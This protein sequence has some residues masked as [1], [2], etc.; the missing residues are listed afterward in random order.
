MSPMV[1]EAV[2][3]S[4][5]DVKGGTW[6]PAVVVDGVVYVG[7][8]HGVFAFESAISRLM[9]IGDNPTRLTHQQI[10]LLELCPE[11]RDSPSECA[12]AMDLTSQGLIDLHGTLNHLTAP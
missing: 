8:G 10:L 4:C 2:P 1:R 9:V 5:M 7:N 6:G 3:A 12:S 11:R